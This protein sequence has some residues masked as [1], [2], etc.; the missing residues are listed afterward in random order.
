MRLDE[1]PPLSRLFG[2][3][4][5]FPKIVFAPFRQPVQ[6]PQIDIDRPVLVIPGMLSGD[7]STAFLRHSLSA[8]GYSVQPA[9]LGM[10]SV[11]SQEK[12]EALEDL[13]AL[14]ARTQR[15][16]IVVI[17]WSLGGFYARVLAQRHFEKVE[18]IATLGTPFSG[19]RHANNA[20]QFYEWLAGHSVDTPPLPDDPSI[21]PNC[22]TIAFWSAIDGIV[23]PE[24]SKGTACERDEAVELRCRH[25][26]MATSR[27]AVRKIVE[28]I[29]AYFVD[30]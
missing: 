28:T 1:P 3:S 5:A 4:L 7:R 9:G 19:D 6:L 12:F 22:H 27:P 23:A 16:K 25:F 2:E 29:N 8:S 26:E 20:W 13:L 11:I 21:K 24:S 15:R 18:L 14:M 10:N 30:K 17:G